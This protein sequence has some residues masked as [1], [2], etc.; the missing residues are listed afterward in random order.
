MNPGAVLFGSTLLQGGVQ[1]NWA[2]KRLMAAYTRKGVFSNQDD[3]LDGLKRELGKRFKDVTVEVVGCAALFSGRV[4]P[5][6]T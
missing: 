3:D 4:I 1:R 5:E 2:A 6:L